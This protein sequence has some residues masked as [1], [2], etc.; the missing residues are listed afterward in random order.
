MKKLQVVLIG[1]GIASVAGLYLLPKVVVD[2][3]A[4]GEKMESGAEPSTVISDSHENTLSSQNRA[5]ADQL[6]AKGDH[7]KN[8]PLPLLTLSPG[9]YFYQW[10]SGDKI[11]KGKLEVISN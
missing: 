11:G 7:N 5:Q 9:I 6:I 4:T 1:I 10:K 2:N 3:E 8:I